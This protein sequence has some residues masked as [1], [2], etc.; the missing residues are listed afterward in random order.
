MRLLAQDLEREHPKD[1]QGRG[2]KLARIAEAAIPPKNRPIIANASAV[3]LIVSALVLLIACADVANLLLARA[4]NRSRDRRA[5]GARGRRWR[6]LRQLLLESVLLALAG[7]AAGLA[8]A[9]WAR[10]LLWSMRPP[11]FNYAAVRLR[12]EQPGAGL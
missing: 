3:L 11:M 10:D 2:V 6:V 1:N 7:G 8:F 4:A 9:R 5:A 12:L